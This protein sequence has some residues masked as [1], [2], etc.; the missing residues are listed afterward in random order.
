MRAAADPV[1]EPAPCMK[2]RQ[3]VPAEDTPDGQMTRVTDF[4]DPPWLTVSVVAPALTGSQA[5]V[6]TALFPA[7]MGISWPTASS[8]GAGP[9]R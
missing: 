6:A 5:K 1:P 7:A 4:E 9:P 2:V 3:I 8:R